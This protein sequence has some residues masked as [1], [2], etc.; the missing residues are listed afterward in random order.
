[1][2]RT[3]GSPLYAVD[4]RSIGLNIVGHIDIRRW[5]Q[6]PLVRPPAGWNEGFVLA[7]NADEALGKVAGTYKVTGDQIFLLCRGAACGAAP[8][9]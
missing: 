2:R 9:R 3:G 4:H 7:P 8:A 1:M 5:P 6:A